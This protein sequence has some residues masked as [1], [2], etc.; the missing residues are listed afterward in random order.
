MDLVSYLEE[1]NTEERDQKI[2][3]S[4]TILAKHVFCFIKYSAMLK[5]DTY[6]FILLSKSQRIM[7]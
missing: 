7:T 4:G 1:M 6:C 2:Y 3:L 5:S